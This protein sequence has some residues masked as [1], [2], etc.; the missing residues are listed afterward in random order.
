MYSL[1]HNAMK[2]S[3]DFSQVSLMCKFIGTKPVLEVSSKGEPILTSEAEEIFGQ[4][5]RGKVVD[6][7]GRHHRGVGLGLWVAR[8]L[9]LEIGG[10]LTVILPK[11][12]PRLSIFVVHFPEVEEQ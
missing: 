8:K 3:D 11:K 6:Q 9:L 5:T 12:H 10:N 1:I 7:T 4:F 2:Y